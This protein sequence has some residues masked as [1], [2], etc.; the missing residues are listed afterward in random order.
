MKKSE[1]IV[2]IQKAEVIKK[3]DIEGASF[4]NDVAI[5]SD[6][7]VYF[8][9]SDTGFI[10]LYSNGKL[11]AW[12]TE[13]LERP[14]GLY[15]EE[16]RILLTSSGSSDLKIIDKSTRTFETVTNEIGHG[17]GVEFTGTLIAKD[18]W[19]M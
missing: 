2:A 7:S 8:S 10:W 19:N 6:G 17:D 15:V 12:I 13:G 18:D 5:G 4:L 16:A 3:L 14:N 9:D 1:V 11:E